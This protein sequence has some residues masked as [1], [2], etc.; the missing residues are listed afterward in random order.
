MTI[1][2]NNLFFDSQYGFRFGHSTDLAALLEILDRI[3]GAV[4]KNEIP[5]NVYLDL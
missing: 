4:E 5:L 3:I 2:E 1:F